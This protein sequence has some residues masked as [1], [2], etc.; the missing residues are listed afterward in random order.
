[1]TFEKPP[2][3]IHEDITPSAT[4]I[5]GANLYAIS[6]HFFSDKFMILGCQTLTSVDIKYALFGYRRYAD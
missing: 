4:F 3:L 1:M 6:C 5:P 2:K